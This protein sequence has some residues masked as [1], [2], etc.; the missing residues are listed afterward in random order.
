[1]GLVGLEGLALGWS[2]FLDFLGGLVGSVCV[3]G[4]VG[5][6]CLV[7]CWSGRYGGLAGLL[8]FLGKPFQIVLLMNFQLRGTFLL[9]HFEALVPCGRVWICLVPVG[10]QVSETELRFLPFG[11]ILGPFGEQFGS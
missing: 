1:M 5:L 10:V 2:D 3:V 7:E 9:P 8:W 6:V 4:L 11:L